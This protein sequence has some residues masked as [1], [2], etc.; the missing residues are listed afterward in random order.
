MPHTVRLISLNVGRP[1]L[2]RWRGQMVSTGIFK[3]PVEGRVPLRRLNLDGDRQA[4]LTVHGGRE[5]AVY[6]YPSEHYAY[7]RAELPDAELAHGSFGENFTTEGLDETTVNIGD[8][9][10]IGSSARVVV[11]QPRQPCYKLGIR[12]GRADMVKRFHQSR[13]SGF[14]LAVLEE[15]EV[16]AG[17][18][19]VLV[20]R[21][22]NNVTVRDIYEHFSGNALSP[23]MLRRALRIEAL[24]EGWR[25]HFVEALADDSAD[26]Q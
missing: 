22:P 5:K 3:E 21:D 23:D 12:F 1:R 13:L 9:F 4:D 16:G 10:R 11:T 18:E 17:D 24:A 15:G 25:K 2:V 14:Y 19:F 8:E 6:V 26:N 20:K 7:W